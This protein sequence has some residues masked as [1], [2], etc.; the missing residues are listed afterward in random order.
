[1]SGLLTPT[2]TG[3]FRFGDRTLFESVF[4]SGAGGQ[5]AL[6]VICTYV[7]KNED[8]GSVYVGA[9]QSFFK[10]W[11]SHLNRLRAGTHANDQLQAEFNVYG[12]SRFT[13]SIAMHLDSTDALL[14]AEPATAEFFKPEELLNYRIGGRVK[15]GWNAFMN[16]RQER[17]TPKQ[18]RGPHKVS[19][20]FDF[21]SPKHQGARHA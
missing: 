15:D 7:I 10:R 19:R 1:M 4:T 3:T 18:K 11:K 13:I 21:T 6:E 16:R 5:R 2:Y 12:E 8:T 14:D 17:Y 9:T 20:W